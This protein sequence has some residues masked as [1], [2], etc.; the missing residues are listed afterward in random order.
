MWQGPDYGTEGPG[1][2]TSTFASGLVTA[3]DAPPQESIAVLQHELAAAHQ[4]MTK[5]ESRLVEQQIA[6]S[7]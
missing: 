3:Q 7:R 5:M 1:M 2:L 6:L 4:A